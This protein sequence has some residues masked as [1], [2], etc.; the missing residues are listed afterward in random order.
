MGAGSSHMVVVVDHSGSMRK[1]DVPG[2]SSRTAAVY[3]CLARD[4]VEPQLKLG[5]LGKMEVRT[6]RASRTTSRV[7][8]SAQYMLADC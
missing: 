7:L 4:L 3:D 6:G 1:D 2:Y 8:R 5:N